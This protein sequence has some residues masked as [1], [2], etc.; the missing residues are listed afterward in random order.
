MVNLNPTSYSVKVILDSPNCRAEEMV[1][2]YI[3]SYT[4]LLPFVNT[5]ENNKS[6]ISD[7]INYMSNNYNNM[8]EIKKLYK[9]I[10][11]NIIDKISNIN[12]PINI[13]Y[14]LHWINDETNAINFVN[15]IYN[16]SKEYFCFLHSGLGN[17]LFQYCSVYGLAKKNNA[18]FSVFLST[19]NFQHKDENENEIYE[20]FFKLNIN[21]R[22][23]MIKTIDPLACFSNFKLKIK[24]A[25][26]IV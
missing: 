14:S 22:Y 15:R 2:R 26:I 4:L 7:E 6:Q 25:L 5:I 10:N 8:I 20:D 13:P 9:C 3:N 18:D 17:R 1:Y 23:P 11:D 24:Y 16:L 21:E 19:V 12:K